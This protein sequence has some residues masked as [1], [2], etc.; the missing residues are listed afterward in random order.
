MAISVSVVGG[1]ASGAWQPLSRAVAPYFR[2]QKLLDFQ[3][4]YENGNRK[5]A[6]FR[7]I[8]SH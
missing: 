2:A 5:S 3:K 8:F 7:P 4:S 6:I 1:L